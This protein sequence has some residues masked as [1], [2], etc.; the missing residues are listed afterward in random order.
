MVNPRWNVAYA[1]LTRV[2]PLIGVLFG[3]PDN[4]PSCRPH[5]NSEQSLFHWLQPRL[6]AVETLHFLK[7]CNDSYALPPVAP[8]S[9][10]AQRVQRVSYF[11]PS[12]SW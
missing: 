1:H 9:V 8:V 7:E 11:S 2:G 5:T 12:A 6:G 10:V 3:L 4:P